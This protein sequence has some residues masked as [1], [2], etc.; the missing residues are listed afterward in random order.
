MCLGSIHLV[1]GRDNGKKKKKHEVVQRGPL[2][3]YVYHIQNSV[4]ILCYE[5]PLHPLPFW[6]QKN[7]E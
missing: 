1:K 5:Y 4:Q 3:N 6:Q 7:A 2:A